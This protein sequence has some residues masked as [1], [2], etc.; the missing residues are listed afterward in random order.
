MLDEDP[1]GAVTTAEVNGL[2]EEYHAALVAS[3]LARAEQ[4]AT[5]LWERYLLDRALNRAREHWKEIDQAVERREFAELGCERF[6]AELTSQRRE[7]RT[8][9][10]V[11]AHIDDALHRA[12]ETVV[13]ML[14][15]GRCQRA[16]AEHNEAEY[17]QSFWAFCAVAWDHVTRKVRQSRRHEWLESEILDEVER[18]LRSR[19]RQP[20]PIEHVF[21]F[22]NIVIARA[23]SSV[24]RHHLARAPTREPFIGNGPAILP[25]QEQA[26]ERLQLWN[27]IEQWVADIDREAG[28]ERNLRV[29][30]HLDLA[31]RT[32]A[33]IG[34][35]L[36]PSISQGE[37]SKRMTYLCR[38]LA[39]RLCTLLGKE[40]QPPDHLPHG[41]SHR[42]V[43]ALRDMKK[44]VED[45][46]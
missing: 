31:G 39:R 2:A 32:E 1:S 29:N 38:E 45:L 44:N 5:T 46:E 28:K 25:A 10:D 14:L 16:A 33:E 41:W 24:V 43:E 12:A 22:L 11:H 3:D 30:Y 8:L 9:A 37:V 4:I 34:R 42:M 13:L 40:A 20:E 17:Q 19:L 15:V 7:S 23:V 36:T 27:L 26:L 6:V 21:G 18:R 35:T